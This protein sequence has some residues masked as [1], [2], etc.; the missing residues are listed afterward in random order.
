MQLRDWTLVEQ[1][2]VNGMLTDHGYRMWFDPHP[3][4]TH[5][6]TGGIS[7]Y[8][9]HL[10]RGATTHTYYQRTKDGQIPQLW[11]GVRVLVWSAWQVAHAETFLD[12][13]KDRDDFGLGNK[14]VWCQLDL[15]AMMNLGMT[16]TDLSE[17][18]E[19]FSHLSSTHD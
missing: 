16:S 7:T 13:A 10:R 15:T 11:S 2:H 9:T 4:P 19:L 14:Y 18:D 17:F 1:K 6:D 12:F 5:N 3:I 8:K